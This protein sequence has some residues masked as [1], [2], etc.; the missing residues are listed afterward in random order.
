MINRPLLQSALAV[1][2]MP[3]QI[4]GITKNLDAILGDPAAAAVLKASI[5][6]AQAALAGLAA[7]VVPPT[8]PP[9]P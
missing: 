1:A 2:N 4:A 5:P 3:L 9:A 8:P 6:D 7:A